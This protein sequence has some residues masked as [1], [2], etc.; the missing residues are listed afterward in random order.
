MYSSSNKR[1]IN[2]RL[3]EQL[4]NNIYSAASKIQKENLIKNG[5]PR[6]GCKL[7]N[8]TKK[9][10]SLALQGKKQSL[11]TIEKRKCTMESNKLLPNYVH[12]N[13]NKRHT[14]EYKKNMSIT[15]SKII[16][17]EEWNKKN[18]ESNTGR[19]HIAN[20]ITKQRKRP[21]KED[22]ILLLNEPNSN[23]IALSSQKQI[24]DTKKED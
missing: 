14:D 13:T 6:K 1:Y 3:Y 20:I 11:E 21:K 16:K 8:E 18:S 12:G 5:H 9:L 23:W 17:S 7:S 4:K 22:A 19:I 2:S 24:P 15:C 10:I